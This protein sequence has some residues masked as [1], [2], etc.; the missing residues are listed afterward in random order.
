MAV[1]LNRLSKQIKEKV[2]Y[3]CSDPIR[4]LKVFD[5]SPNNALFKKINWTDPTSG[6]QRECDIGYEQFLGPEV[7]FQPSLISSTVNK[8]LPMIVVESVQS[9]PIDYRR[10]LFGNIVLSGGSTLF[11]NFNKRLEHDIS[12]ILNP[13]P[14]VSVRSNPEL[15]RFAVWHGASVLSQTPSF[16]NLLISR[17]DY[18]ENGPS[19]ARNTAITSCVGL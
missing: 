1:A 19:I 3:V 8:S 11:S 14:P 5:A 12:A 16:S 10:G 4:E 7:F 6:E 13:G 2:T 9:S 18:D 17:K 15:Q